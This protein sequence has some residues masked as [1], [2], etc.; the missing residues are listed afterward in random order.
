MAIKKEILRQWLRK[1]S[2]LNDPGILKKKPKTIFI[3]LHESVHGVGGCRCLV[4]TEKILEA[5]ILKSK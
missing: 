4:S 3:S 1:I 2:L 5:Y